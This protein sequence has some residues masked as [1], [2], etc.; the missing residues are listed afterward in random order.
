MAYKELVK[1]FEK[2]REYMR[3]FYVYGFRTRSDFSRKSA[4]SYDDERRRVE[5]WLG[6]AMSFRQDVSGKRMFISVD[7]RT[8]PH[9]PLFRAFK[10]KSFTDKDIVLHFYI[11]DC[12]TDGQAHTLRE[13]ADYVYD[14]VS[15]TDLSEEMA[16]DATVRN[17]LKEYSKIGLIAEEKQGRQMLYRLN[18]KSDKTGPEKA[19]RPESAQQA[20][21]SRQT[22]PAQLAELLPAIVFSSETMPLGVVGSFLLDKVKTVPDFLSFKHHYLFSTFDSEILEALLQC[23]NAG[24]RAEI[25][26]FTR[27]SAKEYPAVIYPLKIFVSTQ[28]GRE[29]LL[30]Y[31]YGIRRP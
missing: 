19:Q 26:F 12:L 5:S 24:C 4:R 20:E 17:K 30:A 6:D 18:A 16:D 10:A 2:I 9:N 1:N 3:D 7:S 14:A 21:P 22:E 11:L 28:N 27:R 31:N 15:S 29:N 23:R 8:L 13:I 25:R